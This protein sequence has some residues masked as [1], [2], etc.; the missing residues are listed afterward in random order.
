MISYNENN[1]YYLAGIIDGEGTIGLGTTGSVALSVSNTD[2][3]LHQ[4]LLDNYGGSVYPHKVR[5]NR[6][7]SYEWVVIGKK[8]YKMLKIIRDK[9]KLKIEQADICIAF[10]EK[11]TRWNFSG[12]NKRKPPW[13]VKYVEDC[14]CKIHELNKRGRE[15]SGNEEIEVP[16]TLKLR[17][18]VLDEWL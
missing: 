1:L 5:G 8:A 3:I 15:D 17:K 10:Y 4:W 2:M 6:K 16:A 12:P 9:L 14:K 7:D 13:A 11:I 18:D